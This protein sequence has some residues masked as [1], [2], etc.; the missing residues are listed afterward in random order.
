LTD[1]TESTAEL[2]AAWRDHVDRLKAAGECITGEGFPTDPRMR[3]EGYRYLKRI[4]SL[5]H[6]IYVEFPSTTQPML[7]RYG[8]DITPFGATNTDNN[9]Y[10][11]MVD[12]NG[13]Y[14]ISG[15]VSGVKEL[16]FSVQ[17]GEF[18]FGKVAVLAEV[19]LGDLEIGADGRL[20]LV[21]GGPEREANWLPLPAEAVYIN[22]REFVADWERDALA[23]LH[24]ERL[25]V[26]SPPASLTPTAMITAL[27]QSASWVEASVQVWNQYAAGARM[28]TPVNELT[29]PQVAEGGALNMLHGAT[30]W[31]LGPGQALI[32]EFDQPEV[33]YWSIQAYV[34]DWLQP[35][36]FVNRVTSLNDGQLHVDDDG[37]VRVVL[38]HA[39]PGVANW[40][41]T[42]GLAS[43]LLSY[44]YVK[45]TVAPAPTTKLVALGEVRNHLPAST[46][47]F[48]PADRQAQ[49]ASRRRGIARR[50]RR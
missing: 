47:A 5:A 38:A 25:D 32:A 39:D 14:R 8:D 10:R 37:K 31:D 48:G 27:D 45:A 17:D 21:L 4:E 23:V 1:T 20:D 34:L 42:S 26:T 41:D 40:L 22:V 19:G 29:A 43:G 35:L 33:T 46:P 15:D 3:A 11:A 49:I 7:F 18:V 16:L 28:M 6:Q 9:Y 36:D 24:I 2:D 12:P 44:R 13:T 50:F 30:Q